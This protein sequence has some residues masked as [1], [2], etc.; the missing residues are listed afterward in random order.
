MQAALD[1]LDSESDGQADPTRWMHN[2]QGAG[3]GPLTDIVEDPDTVVQQQQNLPSSP[4]PALPCIPETSEPLSAKLLSEGEEGRRGQHF[5]KHFVEATG[6]KLAQVRS[7]P[8]LQCTQKDANGIRPYALTSAVLTVVA[9]VQEDAKEHLQASSPS[10]NMP[11]TAM[12]E[13]LESPLQRSR[14]PTGSPGPASP[15]QAD[16]GAA[17]DGPTRRSS[18]RRKVSFSVD[19]KEAPDNADAAVGSAD[20]QDRPISLQELRE[21]MKRMNYTRYTP[22]VDLNNGAAGMPINRVVEELSLLG[23]YC[24]NLRVWSLEA[25]CGLAGRLRLSL[26]LNLRK[27]LHPLA[28]VSKHRK[29]EP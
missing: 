3:P 28:S 20:L 22:A 13:Q 25:I 9:A 15:L 24:F 6:G 26:R 2:V 14:R 27:G 23:V 12:Q 7:F 17:A 19:S 29:Q 1:R 21:V 10:R 16:R 11:R 8:Q 18:E 5:Y 4:P